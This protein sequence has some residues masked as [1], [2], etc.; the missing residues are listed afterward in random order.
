MSE[1]TID[2][3]VV[4]EQNNA[5]ATSRDSAM[6]VADIIAQVKLIQDVMSKVMQEGEHYGKIPGCGERKTLLQPGAQKLTM[7]F[8]LAPEYQIQETNYD[9]GHKEYRVICTLKSISSGAFVGQGVGCCSTLE[10][11]YRWKG[12]ARKCPECGKEAIIKGKADFGGGWLCWQKKGGCGEKWPDGD[13]AIEGQSVDKVEHD[14]PADFY[15]TVLKMAKKRAF[16]DAT[17]TATAASD[18]FTQDIGDDDAPADAPEPA[19]RPVERPA[20]AKPSTPPQAPKAAQAPRAAASTPTETKT[21]TEEEWAKFLGAC[22]ARLLT[23]IKPED[24][25]VW[26]YYGTQQS[27]I[28][29]HGESLADAQTEKMFEGFSRKNAKDSAKAIMDKHRTAVDAIMASC[30]PVFKGE[31]EQGLVT[32]PRQPDPE[33]QDPEKKPTAKKAAA[34]AKPAAVKGHPAG[35]PACSSTAIKPHE[36]LVNHA[37]CQSCGVM[38]DVNNP[39]NPIE[40]HPWMLARLPFA[41]KA[42]EKKRYKGMTLGQL[43]RLDSK[44]WFG[45]V[46]NYTAEPFQGRPPSQESVDFAAACEQAR[47]HLDEANTEKESQDADGP[48]REDDVPM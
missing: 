20:A 43:S 1:N 34:A 31:V 6:N 36:D 37:W 45:I 4:R 23:L 27:W 9:K 11:K 14:S 16:V 24:E 3:V 38:W 13:Q 5:V 28:L 42:E 17:I 26:W 10:G 41:P 7:T 29:P 47:K 21:G 15:N 40:E 18:I 2:A 22:K 25:W 30:D 44:Y 8:R 46:M 19:K 33:P 48:P 32:M 35:C 12:G 39:S